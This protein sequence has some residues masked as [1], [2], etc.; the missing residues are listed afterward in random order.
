MKEFIEMI[1]KLMKV[2][3]YKAITKLMLYMIFFAVV[4]L[5]FTNL[6]HSDI[7]LPEESL[8]KNYTL[9]YNDIKINYNGVDYTFN[10]QP[11]PEPFSY[12]LLTKEDIEQ[13]LKESVEISNINGTTIKT[14]SYA[15]YELIIHNTSIVDERVVTIEI[16][17]NKIK[18]NLKEYKGYDI[19]W[20]SE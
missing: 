20:E 12:D 11:L 7:I 10:D 1:K 16:K 19:L 13:L 18:I 3:R 14:M 2:P 8:E 9:T 17:E 5:L 6:N 4:I 15:K